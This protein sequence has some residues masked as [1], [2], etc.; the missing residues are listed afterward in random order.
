M[1]LLKYL[2]HLNLCGFT[3]EWTYN[4]SSQMGHFRELKGD[5]INNYVG[6]TDLYIFQDGPEQSRTYGYPTHGR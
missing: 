1:I 2:E 4:L 6:T 3:D 5:T